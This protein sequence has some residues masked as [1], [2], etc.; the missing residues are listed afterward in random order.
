[1][2]ME[3]HPE[4]IR[5]TTTTLSYFNYEIPVLYVDDDAAYIPIVELCK[6]L[7]LCADNHIPKWRRLFLWEN[8]RKLPYQTPKSGRRSVWCLQAGALLF[9]FSCFNWSLVLPERRIQLEQAT[10]EGMK[11]LDQTYWNMQ[12]RYKAFRR[13]LF[14]FITAY[15]NI[16]ST[17]PRFSASLHVC[18]DDF[19][20]CIKWEDIVSQGKNIIDMALKHARSQLLDQANVPVIDAMRIN[21]NGEMIEEFSL[22]LLPI[23]Q[24]ENIIQ[25]FENLQK[26]ANWYQQMTNFL[27]DHGVLWDEGREKW[28]L[29]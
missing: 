25:F 15:S 28:Y 17:L 7:G 8:A 1:M 21:M 29:A 6:M 3:E 24:E 11:V 26:V 23:V 27:A 12:E 16:E 19:D 2:E 14:T 9:W 4:H 22:P 20:V 5:Q 18:L 10:S 13:E